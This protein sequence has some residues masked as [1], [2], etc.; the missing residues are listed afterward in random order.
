M[1]PDMLAGSSVFPGAEVIRRTDLEERRAAKQP[2]KD[3]AFEAAKEAVAEFEDEKISIRKLQL[4]VHRKVNFELTERVW[5]EATRE[6][7]A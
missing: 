2:L 6:I 1:L 7:K 5:I 3:C 4:L